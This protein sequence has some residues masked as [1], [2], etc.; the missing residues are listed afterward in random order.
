LLGILL[1]L[2]RDGIRVG[3]RGRGYEG[4]RIG[5]A[6]DLRQD[7]R[8]DGSVSDRERARA[9]DAS[10]MLFSSSNNEDDDDDEDDD[11]DCAGTMVNVVMKK[12]KISQLA[13]GR[14]LSYTNTG[15]T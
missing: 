9:I 6:S 1:V 13:A 5:T 2:A 8:H 4:Q 11:E 14:L 10:V 12:L 3:R 7:R 15:L